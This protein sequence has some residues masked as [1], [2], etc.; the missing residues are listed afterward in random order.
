MSNLLYTSFLVV[1]F[2]INFMKMICFTRC[3]SSFSPSG[4]F[5]F[6]MH[7]YIVTVSTGYLSGG[8]MML[9][10]FGY[11][12]IINENKGSFPAKDKDEIE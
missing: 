6:G 10:F 9:C 1:Y 4:A 7:L 8:T 2:S 12:C 5:L 3:I 11:A